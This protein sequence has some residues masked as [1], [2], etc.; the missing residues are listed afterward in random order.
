M[1]H[2][3]FLKALEEKH[4]FKYNATQRATCLKWLE[5][6]KISPVALKSMFQ[7][8]FC[9]NYVKEYGLIPQE[10]EFKKALAFI[11]NSPELVEYKPMLED[12]TRPDPKLY[13]AI[14][15]IARAMIERKLTIDPKRMFTELTGMEVRDDQT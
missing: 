4:N 10:P 5:N 14:G 3:L 8:Y 11:S 9:D 1:T 6:K 13:E 12:K 15:E 7:H 2:D